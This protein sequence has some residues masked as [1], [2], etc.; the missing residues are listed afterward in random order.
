MRCSFCQK[1]QSDVGKLISSPND[2]DPVYICDECVA[3]CAFIIEDD[4][5]GSEETQAE[6]ALPSEQPMPG[7]PLASELM[8][9]IESWI[10]EESLGGDAGTRL[11]QVRRLAKQML[12]DTSR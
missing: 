6:G 5:I 7:H 4:R 11:N 8:A 9:A 1:A 10:L 3:V 2:R 12:Q